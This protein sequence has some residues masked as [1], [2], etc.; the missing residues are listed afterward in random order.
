MNFARARLL[1]LIVLAMLT[2]SFPAFT[3]QLPSMLVDEF[4]DG[5]VNTSV[6]FPI[7]GAVLTEA[8]GALIVT[9]NG[10][11]GGVRIKVPFPRLP[12][13]SSTFG[14]QEWRYVVDLTPQFAMAGAGAIVLTSRGLN[15]LVV[16]S[17]TYDNET[18]RVVVTEGS[19]LSGTRTI[20]V[21]SLPTRARAERKREYRWLP[22]T[23]TGPRCD[24]GLDPLGKVIVARWRFN[25]A[26]AVGA[27]P[28]V[29]PT[30][31]DT[32]LDSITI[33]TSES[34]T[35]FEITRLELSTGHTAGGMSPWAIAPTHVRTSGG[36]TVTLTGSGFLELEPFTIT[37]GGNPASMVQV[38]SDTSIA[39]VTP[40]GTR[41]LTEVKLMT[42]DGTLES[43][44]DM[45]LRYY[46]SS[47]PLRLHTPVLPSA[48]PHVPY[49]MLLHSTGG[50][51]P[52][53]YQFA[54]GHLPPGLSLSGTG[55]IGGTPEEEGLFSFFVN[56]I[57]SSG[58]EDT[59]FFFIE[60]TPAAGIPTLST[61]GMVLLVTCLAGS[62]M[63]VLRRR[64][65]G[66]G[67]DY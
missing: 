5:T 43:V 32:Q 26:S 7:N 47:A 41:G 6:Y 31:T 3:S 58:E 18:D 64:R 29:D 49:S 28:F 34:T 67:A 50:V 36:E 60:V 46:A 25:K 53:V 33:E 14:S 20:D 66:K 54:G 44:M 2:T 61:M 4:D 48:S 56:V 62:A 30:L 12:R 40:P 52:P 21:G 16:D 42:N 13:L 45:D 9:P 24:Y 51:G 35:P 27:V 37:V 8:G 11:G 63:V 22:P 1:A 23:C 15:D 38:L 59:R 55:V 19:L 17:T 10:S 57:D 65:V 39:F